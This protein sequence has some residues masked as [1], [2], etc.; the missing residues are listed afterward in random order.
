MPPPAFVRFGGRVHNITAHCWARYSVLSIWT[1]IICR[2]PRSRDKTAR[3]WRVRRKLS[4]KSVKSNGQIR[5][6]HWNGINRGW[7]RITRIRPELVMTIFSLFLRLTGG[8]ENAS[9]SRNDWFYSTSRPG[10]SGRRSKRRRRRLSRIKEIF[11]KNPRLET[12]V[13]F[14][15]PGCQSTNRKL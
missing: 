6:E 4:V 10:G 7:H 12:A 15:F 14:L 1:T 5:L 9:F 11:D 3:E 2:L 8:G 13:G